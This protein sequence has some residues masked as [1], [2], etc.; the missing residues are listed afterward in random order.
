[1][2]ISR[3]LYLWISKTAKQTW[4]N[5]AVSVLVCGKLY[6]KSMENVW[7]KLWKTFPYIIKQT[8]VGL[9]LG[10]KRFIF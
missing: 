1:M 9:I 5:R 8:S 10:I 6:G 4:Q 7:K 2:F 3:S